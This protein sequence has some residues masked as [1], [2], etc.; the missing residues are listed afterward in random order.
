MS[1]FIPSN[2]KLGCKNSDHGK[3]LGIYFISFVII[4][5]LS[6]GKTACYINAEGFFWE[7]WLKIAMLY[8]FFFVPTKY[9]YFNEKCFPSF[10][11]L[12]SSV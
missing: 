5:C 2:L 11:P 7:N 1:I 9:N 3:I 4:I 10:K 12:K 6:G 8:S